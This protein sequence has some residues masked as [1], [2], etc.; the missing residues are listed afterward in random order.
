MFATVNVVNESR[1]DGLR[2]H[3]IELCLERISLKCPS[4]LPKQTIRLTPVVYALMARDHR[5]HQDRVC[6]PESRKLISVIVRFGYA[7]C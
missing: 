3:R 2:C 7:S 1:F 4:T 6:K 5:C